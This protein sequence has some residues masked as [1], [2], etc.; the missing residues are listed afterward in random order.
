MVRILDEMALLADGLLNWGKSEADPEN[1]GEVD[2][3]ALLRELCDL[4]VFDATLDAPDKLLL[5]GRPIALR[6]VFSNLLE[7]AQRY[8]GHALVRL[9]QQDGRAV[10]TITDDGPGIPEDRLA[11]IMDPFV[12]GEDSRSRE[13]GGTGLGLSIAQSIV[14]SHGGSI[15]L[16]NRAEGSG[17][18]VTVELPV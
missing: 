10:V 17:L 9:Q 7:N 8:A 4:E 15:A 13:T 3:S 18:N 16:S 11:T 12:R 14:R 5:T 2:L 1:S 6:R